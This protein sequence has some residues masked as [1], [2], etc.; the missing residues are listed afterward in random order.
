MK[1]GAVPVT[2][3]IPNAQVN[4]AVEE[5]EIVDGVMQ[6]P[7]GPWIVSWYKETP[8]L[9]AHGNTVLAGHKDYWE[10]G[11]SIF[12]SIG[13]LQPGD[14][15]AV[16]GDNGKVYT[17]KVEW[18][19]VYDTAT[20]PIQEIVGPTESRALTLITCGGD[21]DYDNGVYLSRT[22]VRAKYVGSA[23]PKQQ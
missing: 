21:F 8:K 12:Y 6:D 19:R 22:V 15:I 18:V 10:V 5:L 4:A 3:S 17:Y 2:I 20:A 23:T 7:T 9:G 16:T 11:P 13:D 1:S 14:L